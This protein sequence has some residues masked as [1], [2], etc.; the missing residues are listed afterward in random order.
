[1]TQALRNRDFKPKMVRIFWHIIINSFMIA[2]VRGIEG[3]WFC[4][5]ILLLYTFTLHLSHWIEHRNTVVQS[6]KLSPSVFWASN[7]CVFYIKQV[8]ALL[9]KSGHHGNSGLFWQTDTTAAEWK[10]SPVQLLSWNILN[11]RRK[12]WYESRRAAATEIWISEWPL[13]CNY[14]L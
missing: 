3:A 5:N 6:S 14:S 10:W 2:K 4:K 11:K 9:Q 1:M 7:K 13:S 12:C 8:I